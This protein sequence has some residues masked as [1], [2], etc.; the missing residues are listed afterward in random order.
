MA[1]SNLDFGVKVCRIIELVCPQFGC[2][3]A[4]TG[5][6]LYKQGERKDL[7]VLFYRIRQTPKI[8]HEGLFQALET[9]GFSKPTGRGWVCKSVYENVNIDMFF[10]EELDGDFVYGEAEE[11]AIQAAPLAPHAPIPWGVPQVPVIPAAPPC[12]VPPPFTVPKAFDNGNT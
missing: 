8:D 7:D 11:L 1:N 3:V 5:G 12:P 2:H 9:L 10:P 6:S 4:L